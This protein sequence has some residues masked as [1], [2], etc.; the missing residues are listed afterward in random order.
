MKDNNVQCENNVLN[1]MNNFNG[2]NQAS[3]LLNITTYVT[4]PTYSLSFIY[5]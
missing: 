5:M 1:M 4:A 2:I 3:Y